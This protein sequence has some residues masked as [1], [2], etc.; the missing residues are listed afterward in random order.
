MEGAVAEEEVDDVAFVGLQPVEG[1]GFYGADVQTVD[2]GRVDQVAG[3]FGVGCEGRANERGADFLK[4]VCLRAFHHGGEG[5]HV[6]RLGNLRRGTGAMDDGR[7]Q[8]IAAFVFNEPVAVAVF[9]GD[10]RHGRVALSKI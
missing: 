4:H 3:P 8:I 9:R 6:L 1:D 7:P 5:E 10:F 2:V